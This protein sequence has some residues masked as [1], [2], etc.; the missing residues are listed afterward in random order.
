MSNKLIKQ[1]KQEKKIPFEK[2]KEMDDLDKLISILEA[3][4]SHDNGPASSRNLKINLYANGEYIKPMSSLEALQTIKG[5]IVRC[6]PTDNRVLLPAF[7]LVPKELLKQSKMMQ[8][9]PRYA[10]MVV[11][12][13]KYDHIIKSDKFKE[14]YMDVYAWACWRFIMVP[15]K[16]GKYRQIPG[17]I[18]DFSGYSNL[19][20]I[21]YDIAAYV[22]GK[23]AEKG[24]SLQWLYL[25]SDDAYMGYVSMEE[26]SY[27][28]AGLVD[29]II[30]ENDLQEVIDTLWET[31]TYEDYGERYSKGKIDAQRKWTHS[32]ASTK[33]ISMEDALKQYSQD[34]ETMDEDCL[35]EIADPSR[36]FEG[37]IMDKEMLAPFLK[38]LNDKDKTILEMKYEGYTLQE[39]ADAV[40]Y[41]THSAV[42]KRIKA[43]TE[44]YTDFVDQTYNDFMDNH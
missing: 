35:A 20:K 36:E 27:I 15:T 32:R 21:G 22:P 16:D 19:W 17:D 26:F 34:G 1:K 9:I 14:F 30:Y 40:G 11:R 28:V 2:E 4:L 10:N 3:R 18:N 13:K 6:K 42:S 41:K 7:Y 12:T 29:E 44:D 37:K 25:L 43:I 24:Y 5:K 39:I 31:R 8:E 33:V 23:L 38:K